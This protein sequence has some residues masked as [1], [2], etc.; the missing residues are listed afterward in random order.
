MS[1]LLV[2][3]GMLTAKYLLVL[4]SH[5]Y[6]YVPYTDRSV[7]FKVYVFSQQHI[8]RQFFFSVGS[9]INYS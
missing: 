2:I 3:T 1:V 6:V 8:M 7:Y 4:V 5:S 9:I